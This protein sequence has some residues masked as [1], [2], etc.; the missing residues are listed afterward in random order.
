MHALSDG[1]DVG[2][3]AAK[4]VFQ[5]AH[6]P[7]P[8]SYA[9]DSGHVFG[10]RG[11]MSYGWDFDNRANVRDR[12]GDDS[13]D[14]PYDTFNHTQRYGVRTWEVA[15]PNGDYAVRVVAGD[16][17]ATNSVY[18]FDV[19]GLPVVSG[20]PGKSVRFF[21]G[22]RTITVA[23][24]RLT[25]SNS[26]GSKNNKL[27]VVEIASV[28]AAPATVVSVTAPDASAA[29]AG[30]DAG[31]FRVT[32][33]G[34]TAAALTVAYTLGGTA[35]NGADY[36]SLSGILT[37]PAGATAATVNLTPRS[38][39]LVEGVESVLLVLVGGTGYAVGTPGGAVVAIAD[40]NPEPTPSPAEWK[41]HAP[42]PVARF[43]S[44]SAAIDGK[45][46]VFGGYD[47]N[48][49]AMTRSDAY[50]PAADRWTRIADM[51][52]PTTHAGVASD[53]PYVYFAGGFVGERSFQTTANVWRYD[54]RTN[55]WAAVEPLP[56]QRAAGGLVRVG[57]ELHFFGGTNANHRQD[58]GEHWVLNLDGAPNTAAGSWQPLAPLPV[59]RNHVGYAAVNGRI[60]CIGGQLLGDEKLG[61]VDD[62][63]AFDPA[64]GRWSAVADLPIPLSHVHTSTVVLDGRIIT[65]G[66]VSNNPYFPRTVGDVLSYDPA[67]NAWAA[68]PGLPDLRQAAVAQLIGDRMYVT[69]GTPTGIRPQPTTWSRPMTNTWDPA[70][71]L[72][73]AL[74]EVAGGVVGNKL[75]LVGEG[76]D[77]TLA[78]DLTKGTWSNTT[79]LARRPFTGHHHAA[80][81]V[82]GKLYLF[83]GL[84]G[85]S[86][87]KVQIYDPAANRW[88]AGAA[89]PFAAGSVSSAVI[90]G[91]VYV[92][93][94]IVGSA[95]ADRTARYDPATNTWTELAPM[96]RGRNHAAASTDGRRL[97]V[98]GGRGAGSGDANVVANGFD[99]VQIYNPATNNWWSSAV[100]GSDL[101]PLPQ[102]RGG[103]G[104]AVYHDG[105]FYVLGG[106]TASG[107]GATADGVYRRV[108]IYN[109]T[110]NTWRS[111]PPMPTAR[112]GIFP[113]LFAG[114]IYVAGGG[115]RAGASSS[116]VLEILT[117]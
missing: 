19:E 69:T 25:V 31:M 16:P 29:E 60:Y 114:R 32:R 110:T 37:I 13:D 93:G 47:K 48:I 112:H 22:R 46:Y 100:A 55:G 74:A 91:K 68:L 102:A 78:Y 117:V 94:G 65:V 45:L 41:A 4:V 24:G 80:E 96:P 14:H 36:N 72:P 59:P 61:N 42:S 12:D 87:G 73:A 95:T 27:A 6:T 115:T 105:E 82:N 17:V 64:T 104:N 30:S 71:P 1:S 15:V 109:P 111:G 7:V 9:A 83:G 97:F 5:P 92:A 51:P 50:D 67:A 39:A 53:G 20:R 40:S 52:Q 66:G 34:P 89:M 49:L 106:E 38:D 44:G 85:S 8:D 98:F 113:L 62:V 79:A 11:G 116:A 75:Y 43:E 86:P 3:F 76:S 103:M 90:D 70:A 101:R 99:T 81:V 35:T 10:D 84:G 107:A 21:E 33:T 18:G 56:A 108:D 57:R 88:T 54:S 58:Y 63:H 23:D 77:A 2:D 26:A 28:H